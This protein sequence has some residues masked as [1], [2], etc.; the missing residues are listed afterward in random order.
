M[1]VSRPGSALLGAAL[2]L[3]V[4][5]GPAWRRIEPAGAGFT[6][7]MPANTDCDLR[8]WKS[9]TAKATWLSRTCSAEAEPLVSWLRFATST[10]IHYGISWTAVPEGLEQ[11]SLETVL[12]EFE[13]PEV[14]SRSPI[15]AA[16]Q[17]WSE[18]EGKEKYGLDYRTSA[19]PLGGVPG[20]HR[21]GVPAGTIRVEGFVYRERLALRRGRLYRLT[22][23]GEGGPRLDG[24]WNRMLA[25]FRFVEAPRT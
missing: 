6:V 17:R 15:I 5:C 25:S 11:A 13:A 2:L 18:T 24:I 22:V 12:A 23:D 4:A 9:V 8:D 10:Y 3:A 16:G 14:E 7:Q 20:L 1:I 21:D 19:A